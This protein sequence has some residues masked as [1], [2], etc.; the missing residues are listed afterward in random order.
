MTIMAESSRHGEYTEVI[1]CPG[2]GRAI[3]ISPKV[4]GQSVQCPH[5]SH[6]I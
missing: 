3:W 6:I 5:C 4:N 1:K 2:C